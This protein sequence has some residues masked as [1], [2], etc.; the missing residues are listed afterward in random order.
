MKRYAWAVV[1]GIMAVAYVANEARAE[2]PD[3]QTVC[4]HVSLEAL[5]IMKAR[6]EGMDKATA[7]RHIE[8]KV[9]NPAAKQGYKQ[10]IDGA[11]SIPIV[12]GEENKLSIIGAYGKA[13]YQQCMKKFQFD[14]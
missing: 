14:I 12:E 13:V 2:R 4:S 3:A 8:D 10:L 7:Y 1:F 6:Q 9:S 5:Y 11:W